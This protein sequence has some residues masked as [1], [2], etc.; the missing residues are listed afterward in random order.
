MEN[1]ERTAEYIARRQAE[2]QALKTPMETLPE[3]VCVLELGCG[4]GHFL[5]AY[6]TK[7]VEEGARL[8]FVGVDKNPERIERAHKKSE[9]AAV[10]INWLNAQIEDV[11][12]LWPERCR[13]AEVFV[14]FPDPWPKLKQQKHRFVNE[15]L[16]EELSRRVSPG[17]H[18]YFR[19][20]HEGY[21][22][23]VEELLAGSKKW[24]RTSEEAWP[25]GLPSTVFEGHH[26]R[27]QSLI[28]AL[29]EAN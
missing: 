10:P 3:G 17:A 12:S 7:R 23:A 4:H 11:L 13:I 22:A 20:D 28:A 8:G 14:L 5:T 15:G 18:F 9:R 6:A 24:Q 2:L 29:K 27:Y 1:P 21:F 19:T 25:Q 16:L 26:P